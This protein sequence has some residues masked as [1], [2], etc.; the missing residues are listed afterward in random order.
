M[1]YVVFE[2]SKEKYALRICDVYEIIK[3]QRITVVH[4]T[5]HFLEGIINLRGKIVPVISLHKKFGLKNYETTKSTRIIFVKI[6]DEMVGIVVD[7]VNY[8]TKFSDIQPPPEMVAGIDGNN[9]A[10]VGIIDEG[11][12]S[13]L[14]INT[15]LND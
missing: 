2:L 6:K 8:V 5:K 10:G 15:I 11:V 7:K 4:N 9:F 1:Q 13:I 14:E 3:M 12:A